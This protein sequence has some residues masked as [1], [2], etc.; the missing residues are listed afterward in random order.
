MQTLPPTIT[1]H[2]RSDADR[3]YL[4]AKIM[5]SF[6]TGLFAFEPPLFEKWSPTGAQEVTE[7]IQSIQKLLSIIG[8]D[9][10]AT[11]RFLGS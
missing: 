8:R 7:L 11:L 2:L 6:P 5:V 1:V 9:F 4:Q 3:V 10:R